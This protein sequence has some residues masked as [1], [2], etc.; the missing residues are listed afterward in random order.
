MPNSLGVL[1]ALTALVC[2]GVGDFLI[3]R[4]TRRIGVAPSLFALGVVGSAMLLPFATSHL[5]NLTHFPALPILLGA[6]M[7]GLVVAPI[8]FLAFQRGKL[9]VVSPILTLEL[10]VTIL[11]GA[12]FLAEQLTAMQLGLAVALFVGIVLATVRSVERGTRLEAGAILALLGAVGLGL[13]NLLNGLAAREVG[14]VV[15]NWFVRSAFVVAVG[16]WLVSRGRLSAS[17]H[18]AREHASTVI[19]AG[20]IDTIAWLAYGYAATQLPIPLV[21]AIAQG[22]VALSTMLGVVF[23][24]ERLRPHQAIGVVLAIVCSMALAAISG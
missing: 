5:N 9:S 2:W 3:Q 15:A 8:N 12:L 24:R 18:S 19:P 4:S 1:A 21:V 23:N 11:L 13:A 16:V 7:L 14:P 17:L 22:Y 6:V 20:I 10:F